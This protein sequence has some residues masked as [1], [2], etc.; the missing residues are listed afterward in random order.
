M[1]TIGKFALAGGALLVASFTVGST[2]AF[3]QFEGPHQLGLLTG[4]TNTPYTTSKATVE[5]VAGIV[6]FRGA[7][8]S[9]TGEP[10]VLPVQFRPPTDVYVPIDVCNA[11]SARLY[12]QSN[13][14]VTIMTEGAFSDAQCYTSLDGVS[15]AK[16]ANGF[17]ALTLVNGWTNAPFATRD[18][19]A[20]SISGIVHLEG[21]IAS[22]S[23]G[24]AFV[25]PASLRPTTDVYVK[26]DLCGATNGRLWIQPSGVVTVQAGGGTFSNA[27]CFT[28]LESAWFVR[29]NT[30]YTPL[31]LINGWT[32]GPFG[33]Q[34]P[35][36]GNAYGIVY[37]QGAM[38]TSG[39]NATPFVLPVAFRPITNVYV[40]VD[41]CGASNGGL[42]IESTG[43]VTVQAEG[44]TFSNAQCFT[45]LD[46][47]S[48]VQ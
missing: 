40:P 43:A 3:A 7:I 12:I 20:R 29:A 14:T 2:A 28:S 48:F 30:G 27:Q 13:G 6:Q 26:V 10:F 31:T 34:Q 47:V 44:G 42:L 9:G 8:A 23:T 16:N 32:G 15:F 17:T 39:S 21:A 19:A 45:S 11:D 22:G 24:E 35:Q 36:A 33:T 25:L 1:K 46:G 41:L 38:S 4:W 18:A 37:F 5:E